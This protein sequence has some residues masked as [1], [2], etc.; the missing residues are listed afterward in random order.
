MSD[1]IKISKTFD[2]KGLACPMPVVK[3]SKG[4]KDVEVGDV[5]EAISTD[6]GSLTDI[7]AWARTTGNEVIK[8]EQDDKVIRFYIKRNA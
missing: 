1:D 7:P 2:L 6:P 3:V 4:I 5:I 8:T